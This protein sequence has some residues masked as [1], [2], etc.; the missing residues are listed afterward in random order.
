MAGRDY[1]G[2]AVDGTVQYLGEA[3]YWQGEGETV[4]I[5]DDTGT[6]EVTT[7]GVDLD[8]Q[9][10]TDGQTTLDEWEWSACR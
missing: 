9:P 6:G 10:E 7:E 3:P 4:D 5:V 2:P 1:D 8:P